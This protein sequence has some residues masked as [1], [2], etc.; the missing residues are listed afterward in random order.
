M[1][2]EPAD[3][4][5]VYPWALIGLFVAV[6]AW[7][8]W[9]HSAGAE[10]AYRV[11]PALVPVSAA[12]A[13]HLLVLRHFD[14]T[15][16]ADR[17]RR[18]AA[19][20]GA[21]VVFG[22]TMVG[23]Y[24][25]LVQVGERGH[26]PHPTALPVAVDGLV[27]VAALAVWTARHRVS[28]PAIV[29]EL[30]ALRL[31][32]ERV[33]ASIPTPVSVEEVRSGVARDVLAEVTGLQAEAARVAVDRY[34]STLPAPGVPGVVPGPTPGT[35]SR[36]RSRGPGVKVERMREFWDRQRADGRT[37]SLAEMDRAAGTNGYAKTVRPGWLAEETGGSVVPIRSRDQGGSG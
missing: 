22:W 7:G 2:T 14:G 31:E 32:L 29:A 36:A 5:N 6:S 16:R 37:P 27:F 26:M 12:F 35:N 17:S 34:I 8:N 20:C 33:R 19:R 15:D 9:L 10:G 23:S 30:A 1:T 24:D 18:L 4:R 13:W 28:P 25:A 3:R 21:A 11:L